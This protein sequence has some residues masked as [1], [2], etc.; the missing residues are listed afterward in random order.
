[1]DMDVQRYFRS[2]LL[3]LK[4]S[5]YMKVLSLVLLVFSMLLVG[6]CASFNSGSDTPAYRGRATAE[7][8]VPLSAP[9]LKETF[10]GTAFKSHGG[11]WTWVFGAYGTAHARAYNG[12]WEI[13]DQKWGIEGDELCRDVE[14]TYTCVPVYA[15]DGVLRFGKVGTTDLERWAILPYSGDI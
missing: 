13:K 14:G 7:G 4:Q 3:T 11:E 9:E 2:D 10:T 6:A 12:A 5:V 15:V 1:M 8:L